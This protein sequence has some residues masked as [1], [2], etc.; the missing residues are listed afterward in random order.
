MV[1]S[2]SGEAYQECW[3]PETGL[4][5]MRRYS[6]LREEAEETVIESKR[7]WHDTAFSVSSLQC[8][9]PVA[10]FQLGINLC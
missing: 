1:N 8:K 7:V 6:A 3:D 2:A 9:P 5:T 4:V 10:S